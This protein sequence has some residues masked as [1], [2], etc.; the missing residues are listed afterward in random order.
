VSRSL[1]EAG[2]DGH[3]RT[4][5]AFRDHCESERAA[6]VYARSPKGMVEAVLAAHGT[7][8]QVE[9]WREDL[10]PQAEVDAV[11]GAHLF[12]A[13]LAVAGP[14]ARLGR[15]EVAAALRRAVP[16]AGLTKVSFA[17]EEAE[18]LDEVEWDA[19]K[20]VRAALPEKATANVVRTVANVQTA[21]HGS[22]VLRRALATLKGRFGDRDVR[23]RLD[24]GTGLR[25][26]D[27]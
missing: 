3:A 17:T 19:F 26:A 15:D 27:A 8:S 23:I 11:V 18:G 14:E 20:K 13:A 21:S 16:G 24:L 22:F 6:A 2:L 12:E 25:L 7:P 5:E 9:R 10:L 4:F 1:D